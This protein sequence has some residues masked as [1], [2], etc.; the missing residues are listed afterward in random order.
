M[1]LAYGPAIWSS[2]E[3]VIIAERGRRGGKALTV[4]GY[5]RSVADRAPWVRSH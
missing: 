4:F 3:A 5:R 1:N 2:A